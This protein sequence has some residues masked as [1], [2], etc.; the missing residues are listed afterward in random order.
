MPMI[1]RSWPPPAADRKRRRKRRTAAERERDRLRK[2]DQRKR[3]S[4][5]TTTYLG[6][7]NPLLT[8]ALIARSID[9][10]MT[11]NEA[12]RASRDRKKVAQDVAEI[13]DEWARR[14][15]RAR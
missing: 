11:E 8:E 9:A 10:G 13:T 2:D 6:R 4:G 1:A 14:Y 3:E 15:L 12:E 7:A 5:G